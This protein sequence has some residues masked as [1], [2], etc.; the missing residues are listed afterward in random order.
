[1]KRVL[2]IARAVPQF[3]SALAIASGL[4]SCRDARA[5]RE[6]SV[7]YLRAPTVSLWEPANVPAEPRRIL[8]ERWDTVVRIRGAATDSVLRLARSI[9]FSDDGFVMLADRPQRVLRLTRAGRLVWSTPD[10]QFV[11]ARDMKVTGNGDVVVADA[12]TQQIVYLDGKTG[13]AKRAIPIS[14]EERVEQIASLAGGHVV[15]FSPAAN[16]PFQV[17]SGTAML[18]RPP[19]PWPDFTKL[20]PLA[21]Q[22]W[23]ASDPRTGRWVF[24]FTYGN[25]FF[26]FERQT[27]R[28]YKGRF[29]EHTEFPTLVIDSSK[30]VMRKRLSHS[31]PSALAVMLADSVISV[32]FA[33]ASPEKGRLI[34]RFS[35][36]DGRYLGSYVLP[37]PLR[38]IAAS[39]TEYAVITRDSVP[40][41]FVLRPAR[42]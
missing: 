6:P 22:G 18:G 23:L 42:R 13:A 12:G 4:A 10:G 29:A 19:F 28:T 27:A 14:A 26:G 5:E 41:M 39:P 17:D 1:M 3:L 38:T 21:R 15:L 30:G 16:A 36:R 35:W 9:A 11:Q 34:D 37:T 40:A 7:T 32:L 25:G 24:A 31:T 33:G 20:E 2:W 8:S